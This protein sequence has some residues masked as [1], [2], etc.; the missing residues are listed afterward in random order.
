[1]ATQ[2]PLAVNPSR[3]RNS[4]RSLKVCLCAVAYFVVS[5]KVIVP[6]AYHGEDAMVAEFVR[7][8]FA[9]MPKEYPVGNIGLIHFCYSRMFKS[10]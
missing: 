7:G 3:P 8:V 10:I 4:K 9:E 5:G 2:L 1:M 6:G